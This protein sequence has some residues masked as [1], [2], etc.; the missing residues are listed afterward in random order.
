MIR[1]VRVVSGGE[2]RSSSTYSISSFVYPHSSS[3]FLL[4]INDTSADPQ[5]MSVFYATGA[6]I[7]SATPFGHGLVCSNPIDSFSINWQTTYSDCSRIVTIEGFA[8]M[9]FALCIIG[10]F[11]II[12]DKYEFVS[13]KKSIYEVDETRQNEKIA[14]TARSSTETA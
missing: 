14:A 8:W 2:D 4:C 9:M 13:T 12:I 1:G 7:I 11:G 6:G 5:A 10:F 3:F